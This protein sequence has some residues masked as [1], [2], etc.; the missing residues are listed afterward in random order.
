MADLG[1]LSEQRRAVVTGASGHV[2]ANL[3]RVLLERGRSVRALIHKQTRALD[4][5]PSQVVRA[6]VLDRKSLIA[7]FA[8][9]DCVY[10]LAAK[11]SVGWEP[12]PV[13]S[14]INVAGTANV[15]EACL[16]VGVRRLVHFSSIQALAPGA[17][18]V[19]EDCRLVDARDGGRGAYDIAK[20]EAERLVLAAVAR[21]LDAV[22]LNPTAVIGPFDFQPSPMGEVLSALA[23]G[24]L[25]ALVAHAQC[26]FVDVRDVASAALAA[27]IQGRSGERYILSGTRLSLVELARLWAKTTGKPAPGFVVPMGVARLAAPFAA[28]WAR[29]RRRRPL[30]TPESLRVLR[31]QR[32]AV[33]CK[34]ECELAYRPRPIEETLR[35]TYGWWKDQGWA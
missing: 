28:A 8:G 14:D 33:R 10:H 17:N 23:H 4:G 13:V 6:D 25:L 35:D 16:A 29:L 26:D 19:D 18:T 20:A 1:G 24:K 27:E 3:V 15:V 11:V 32:S 7:A 21:G 34:A 5:L 31:N 22:I 12:A 2:G 9:A 30:F